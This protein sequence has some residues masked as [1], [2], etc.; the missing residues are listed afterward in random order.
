[1]N[2]N[3]KLL[4]VKLVYKKLF[5]ITSPMT[6]INIYF[7]SGE[8]NRLLKHR[9]ILIKKIKFYNYIISYNKFIIY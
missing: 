6:I 8:K 7:I 3:F 2:F 1:M 4:M 5:M 9:G